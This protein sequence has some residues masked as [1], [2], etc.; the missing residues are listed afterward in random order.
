MEI[1]A[2]YEAAVSS[3]EYQQAEDLDYSFEAVNARLWAQKEARGE[4]SRAE[5]EAARQ[6]EADL[7]A[8]QVKAASKG[9]KGKP[10]KAAR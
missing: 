7:A 4:G 2:Q 10:I 3:G 5:W 8:E 9:K 6:A 1:L